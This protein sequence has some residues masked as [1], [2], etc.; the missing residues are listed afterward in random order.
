MKWLTRLPLIGPLA[1]RAL[2]SRPW[3][4]YEHLQRVQWSR[5]AAAITFSSF[6]AVFPLLTVAA[7]AGA[8]VLTPGRLHRMEQ[9]IAQ[10]VPGLSDRLDIGGLVANAGTVG[11][12]GA[13]LLFLTGLGWVAQVRGCLRA[14]WELPPDQGNPVR[15][16]ALDG[17]I[18]A[19]LGGAG[20][21]SLL[22]SISASSAIGW[23]ARQLGIS[24]TAAGSVLL[25]ALGYV[26][27]I[28]ADFL[29]LVYLLTW[30][31]GVSPPRHAVVAAG[32]LGAVGFE[33]LKVLLAGYLRG[34]AG[35]SMYGAF[36]TPVA[37]LLWINFMAKLL[38][39]C[40]AWT[41][42][43]QTADGAGRAAPGPE[44]GAAEDGAAVRDAAGAPHRAPAPAGRDGGKDPPATRR[45][46]DGRAAAAATASV[47]RGPRRPAWRARRR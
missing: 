7:A 35:K 42:G 45:P 14:V 10:Q 6:I 21:A 28:L 25:P 43:Y 27:A 13:V 41:A 16:K 40:A 5:L 18:L 24:G 20:L 36:G 2:R 15:Q 32:L 1:E 44:G 23:T 17:G 11:L 39:F 30:M 22:V 4:T 38:L 47:P 33:V 3:R 19:G 34:V 29:I 37:L 46:G 12:I 26:V 8:A 31:P 9:R